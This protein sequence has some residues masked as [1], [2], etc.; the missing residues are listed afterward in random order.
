MLNR[1][2][3]A[4]AMKEGRACV[5]SSTESH[6]ASLRRRNFGVTWDPM[7]IRSRIGKPPRPGGRTGGNCE[8]CE[9]HSWAGVLI[10]STPRAS[11]RLAGWL[12]GWLV[13]GTNGNQSGRL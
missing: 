7:G 8:P 11:M 2:C 5:G 4:L 13:G 9:G 3:D 12:A 10:Y 1:S 6:A